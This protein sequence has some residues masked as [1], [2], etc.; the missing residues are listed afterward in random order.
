MAT[1][2]DDLQLLTLTETAS[3]VGLSPSEVRNR[4]HKGEIT[5]INFGPRSMRFSRADVED[6]IAAHRRGPGPHLAVVQPL[7]GPRKV[8]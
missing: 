5:Y 4:A 6:F 7:H 3:L 2:H 8:A 1:P